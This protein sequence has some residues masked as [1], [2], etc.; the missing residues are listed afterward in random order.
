MPRLEWPKRV[1]RDVL[2][3]SGGWSTELEV[4]VEAVAG[5]SLASSMEETRL[6][7]VFW[8]PRLCSGGWIGGWKR[9]GQEPREEAGT[10]GWP[11]RAG[12]DQGQMGM[13]EGVQGERQKAEWTHRG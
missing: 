9:G 8:E 5:R 6:S 1:T 11:E 7:C 12:L 3:V 13:G 4:S 2:A 10:D